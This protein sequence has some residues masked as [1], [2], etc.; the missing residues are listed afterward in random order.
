MDNTTT[1]HKRARSLSGDHEDTGV[2]E[3]GQPATKKGPGC[4]EPK[5][6]DTGTQESLAS[7]SAQTAID[8]ANNQTLA[9]TTGPSELSED[10]QVNGQQ[11]SIETPGDNPIR[12]EQATPIQVTEHFAIFD[13][14]KDKYRLKFNGFEDTS[15]L[16]IPKKKLGGNKSDPGRVIRAAYYTSPE[17]IVKHLLEYKRTRTCFSS[18]SI[19]QFVEG[20]QESTG[21]GMWLYDR[22]DLMYV[23][24][25][26][27][28][29]V[30]VVDC[31][32]DCFDNEKLIEQLK[33]WFLVESIRLHKVTCP[34]FDLDATAK[35][36]VCLILE[37]MRLHKN[38]QTEPLPEIINV[39]KHLL[40][41][42]ANW[43][44][45]KQKLRVGPNVKTDGM[46]AK[47]TTAS[48]D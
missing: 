46:P 7:D 18:V 39:S 43:H 40:N 32:N 37:L 5:T 19:I 14:V 4:G 9:K 16:L 38:I 30:G 2:S 47:Q 36:A 24:Y 21:D 35:Q 15:D 44:G 29:Q 6:N 34:Q 20:P 27:D 26:F 41:R 23:L 1:Q 48:T 42:V 31:R 25:R 12:S 8:S 45:F 22:Q 28:G 33:G 13:D 3:S 17:T 11:A 10:G